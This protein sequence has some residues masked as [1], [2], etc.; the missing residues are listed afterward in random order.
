M[1]SLTRRMALKLFAAGTTF[2]GFNRPGGLQAADKTEGGSV[3]GRWAKTHD[4]VWLGEEFWANPMEDWRIKEG[5]AECLSTGGS[6]N[7]QLVTHQLTNTGAPFRMSVHV[8]QREVKQQDGGVGFRVGVKSDINEYRS[9]CFAKNGIKA[10]VIDGTMVLGNKQQKLSRPAD[11]KDCVLTVVGK[12]EGEKYSLTLIVSNPESDKPLGTLTQTFPT[13]ALLGNVA[14]VSNF[15]PRF[16]RMIGARYRFS[17]WS[18]SGD[19]FTV[20]PEHKFGPILWSQY[21]LS[22]SRGDEGFVMKITA[23]T[24]PL[25]EQ[26]TKDVE[27]FIKQEKEWKSLG[28]AALDTDAWTAT[29]RV[30]H[31]N[32]KEATPF[33]LVYQEKLTDGTELA[34]ERTG[35]I[36]AN[37]EGRPLKLGALTCQKDYGFPYEPVANNLLKVDPDLL[38]FSGDQLYEDHG[39]FG[40][41]RDPAEPAILNY[42]RKFYM[43]GWAFGEAM[44]DRPTICLPDDHDV[45]QGNI[46]GEGGMKMKEGTTSSNG[47]YREPARMVNVVHKTCTAHHPDYADPTPCKQN[48]SVYYGDMVYGGVGFAIIA[49]RQFKSG[50]ERV[51][52]GSGRAD[53]VMDANFDTSVLDKPDL[54]LLGERQEKF[55]ERWCEDWRAHNIKVLFS[56]TVFAGV[57][58]HH[59]SYDG[60]LKADLDSG[61]W[62][63]TARNRTVKIIRKGMPLH[64]NGDQHLTSLSQY[65]ADAQR[66]SCWSFC[67]PAI[68]AGYPRWWRPDELGMPHKNRPQHGLADTGEFIDGFG[69]KVYVYAVGNPEP[70]S[71]KNRYDLAHQKGSGFG[72]VLIDPEK[73]TYTLNSYRFLVD[74]TDG[75]A[76]S[77]FPGWPVTIHQKENGGDNL[78]Q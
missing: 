11:M 7:I 48:I 56:Q 12:P 14:V 62:P 42:L 6:R 63:Q 27:L 43:H 54:V 39:G 74:A 22:D 31:W 8:S 20:S 55:L 36:R 78:I 69:N 77:Q 59:G 25:G 75:K 18:V 15:D 24:G 10:G 34:A 47:G 37:P 44:R 51:E 57:A 4:R 60:Y 76:S 38:Y 29:F 52:T 68:S 46:W 21:S 30:P 45:F 67:T 28:T 50:P 35:I 1:Q 9:N 33:K 3:V 66:D 61:S 73:K 32:E 72:L 13:Q 26:D 41:I 16:K 40:L 49:D 19:A 58:T 71:E 53:H 64:I 5:A 70:A 65:G 23:L 17:D 2:L